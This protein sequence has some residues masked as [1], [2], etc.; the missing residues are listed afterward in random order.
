MLEHITQTIGKTPKMHA[1]KSF[2]SDGITQLLNYAFMQ[3]RNY[4]I[5]QLRNYSI[6]QTLNY[7]ITKLRN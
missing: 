3:L 4:A 6:T 7:S 2:K 1:N 5:T